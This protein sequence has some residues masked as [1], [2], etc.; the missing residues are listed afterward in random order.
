MPTVSACCQQFQHEA[1]MMETTSAWCKQFLYDANSFC[2]MQ[3]VSVWWKQFLHDANNFCMMQT[4]SV[5]YSSCMM[6]T[7]SAWCKQSLHDA[8][9]FCMIQTR[10]WMMQTVSA[11]CKQLVHTLSIG[12]NTQVTFTHTHARPRMCRTARPSAYAF[13]LHDLSWLSPSSAEQGQSRVSA[14]SQIPLKQVNDNNNVNFLKRLM[15]KRNVTRSSR[16]TC[17]K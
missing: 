11:G 1:S 14:L 2:M 4:V 8:N 17:G 13:H 10:F 3:T 16:T 9:R 12:L 15:F 6:Q 7:T 5:W